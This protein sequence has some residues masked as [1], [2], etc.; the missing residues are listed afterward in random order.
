MCGVPAVRTPADT[1]P[2]Q[3]AVTA[4]SPAVVESRRLVL[5]PVEPALAEALVGDLRLAGRLAG[6]ALHRDFPGSGLAADLPAYRRRLDGE[7]ALAAGWGLRL[8]L[9]KQERMV[10]GAIGFAGPPDGTGAVA[11]GYSIVRAHQRRGLAV[12]GVGA[13]VDWAFTDSRVSRV[14]AD[15]APDNIASERVLERL[16]FRRLGLP[17]AGPQR[18]EMVRRDWWQRQAAMRRD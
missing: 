2:G 9:Y 14:L 12:E 8:A 7:P 18:W 17:A 11:V 6:G 5:R 1:E 16:G 10:V 15:C 3:R 13:L 4:T